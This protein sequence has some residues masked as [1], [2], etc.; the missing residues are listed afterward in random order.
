[1]NLMHKTIDGKIHNVTFCL[2]LLTL[3]YNGKDSG[4]E[5]C[6]EVS[7]TIGLIVALFCANS[8]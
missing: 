6:G 7:A 4:K 8:Q 2:C 3:Y 1:M 5:Y